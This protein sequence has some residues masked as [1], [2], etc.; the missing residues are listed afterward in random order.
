MGICH[1]GSNF[2]LLADDRSGKDPGLVAFLG[3]FSPRTKIFHAGAEAFVEALSEQW[4]QRFGA[5]GE[6]EPTQWALPL[7]EMPEG[8]IFI[9]Y[10]REDLDAART[11]KSALD[12]AG[13]SVW[14]D[15]D[16]L[17][18]ERAIAF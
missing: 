11:L 3:N 9:S 8:A 16:Q 13:F 4:R 6:P 12:A 10:A 1:C 17:G 5:T 18:E 2:F 15:L 14:F 7:I